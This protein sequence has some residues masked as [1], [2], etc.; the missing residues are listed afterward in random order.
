MSTQ[1]SPSS[2]CQ[3]LCELDRLIKQHLFGEARACS[4]D[5]KPVLGPWNATAGGPADS[6]KP[7]R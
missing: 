7:E 5:C 3:F 2:L 4:T 6:R 1:E